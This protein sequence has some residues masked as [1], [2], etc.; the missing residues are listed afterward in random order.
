MTEP[1]D[2]AEPANPNAPAPAAEIAGYAQAL[3][4]LDAILRELEDPDLD[5]DRLA[6]QLRR[7]ST[8]IAFCRQRIVGARLE[9]EAIA[10]DEEGG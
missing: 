2:S 1:V 5:V 9:I 6:P 10:Q 7:A 4:E 3:S 8:L